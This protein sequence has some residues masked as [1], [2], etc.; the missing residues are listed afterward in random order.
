MHILRPAGKTSHPSQL[1]LLSQNSHKAVSLANGKQIRDPWDHMFVGCPHISAPMPTS[2][3]FL[4]H[5]E[6]LPLLTPLFFLSQVPW[7]SSG[8]WSRRFFLVS[9]AFP[10]CFPFSMYPSSPRR[11]FARCHVS[12]CCHKSLNPLGCLVW[13]PCPWQGLGLGEF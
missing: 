13:C 5:N 1:K 12:D 11:L 6:A 7:P 3:P 2:R 10:L 4:H 8:P 9:F